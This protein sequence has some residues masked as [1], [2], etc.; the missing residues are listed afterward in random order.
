MRRKILQNNRY[1]IPDKQMKYAFFRFHQNFYVYR[2]KDSNLANG[3]YS[4][5][6]LRQRLSNQKRQ[7]QR[8]RSVEARVAMGV[9]AVGEVHFRNRLRAT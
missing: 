9:I 7:L 4:V 6:L 8:L 5:L 3:S 2:K 1:D